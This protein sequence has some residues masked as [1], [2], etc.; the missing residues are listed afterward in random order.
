MT[1]DA[2]LQALADARGV[3]TSYED[4]LER[5]TEV[6]EATVR[7]VLDAL[8][9][10]SKSDQPEEPR[11]VPPT[12]VI[13]CRDLGAYHP[14]A[15]G[16]VTSAQLE[17]EDGTA[18][19]LPV[20]QGVV[21]LAADLPLGYH[22]L[23]VRGTGRLDERRSDDAVLAVVP[24]RVPLPDSLADSRAWGWMVQ[25]YAV[26]SAGSWGMG[27]FADLA[28]LAR[29][30]AA[31][32]ADVLLVNPLHAVAP[33]F[34][35]EASPYFPASRRFCSPL[36]LRPEQLPEHAAA[37]A[38]VR[39]AVENLRQHVPSG[40]RI[41]RDTVWRAKVAALD[42]L[43]PYAVQRAGAEASG[44]TVGL[45]DF[46][47]YCALAEVH[48]RDT[49]DWPAELHDPRGAAVAAERERLAERVNF[50]TWLQKCCD[51]QLAVAQAASRDAGMA[52]GIVHDLAVGVDPGG[53]DAWALQDDLAHGFTVG[54]PPDGF[55][56]R[57]QDWRLPPWRPDRLAAAGYQPV[58][59]ML[60]AVLARGGGIRIDHILGLYR[61]W[62]VPEGESSGAG[63]YVRYDVDA[64]CGVVALEAARAGALVVGED[65]GTV[66][67]EMRA[68]LEAWGMVG[69]AVLWF[70]RDDAAEGEDEPAFLPP[71]RWRR[72]VMASVTT[73]DL[74]TAAGFVAGEHVRVRAQLGVLGR[75]ASE[76][77]AQA[78]YDQAALRRMLVEQGLAEPGASAVE[79][80]RA[81]HRVPA[82][83]PARVVLAALGDAV[84]DLRQPNLPGTTD[85]Y[86][87]WRLP[88]ADGAGRMM[89]LEDLQASDHVR[90]LAAT[91][92]GDVRGADGEGGEAGEGASRSP[93][94]GE[95]R[96]ATRR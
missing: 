5:R 4:Y 56:Q 64:L 96:A 74:P 87:N 47:T 80:V 39:V 40:D 41:D 95:S 44:D 48:G 42:A 37:P 68:A 94:V 75:P 58:R 38:Q 23:R 57:G 32:G 54:A 36:Y 43:F 52:V 17:L 25:L 70:E 29:W 67:R 93:A 9:G 11:L 76:E 2:Q 10:A 19:E 81:M 30:S 59:D 77:W 27:D 24:D 65:L 72:D 71:V 63:T 50:H 51:E 73:H 55:N 88:V 21:A 90:S 31:Q 49:A 14:P 3:A 20:Q 83:A 62:W 69:S 45:S 86:P 28:E 53:A 12:L 26:R 66:P 78:G 85:E 7:R 1:I 35:V 61:L 34:P 6:P 33:T 92:Q 82:L 46:A 84:G 16:R 15:P 91:L 8:G 13:R 22:R 18:I 60:R 79:I 89:S